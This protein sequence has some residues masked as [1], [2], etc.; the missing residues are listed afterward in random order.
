MGWCVR[1]C[2]VACW[3]RCAPGTRTA[4]A[5]SVE[6]RAR[7]TLYALLGEHPVDR[8]GRCR[9]C[10]G[11]RHRLW[12]RRRVCRVLVLAR[13]YLFQ[14]VDVLLADAA[15]DREPGSATPDRDA[16]EVLPRVLTDPNGPRTPP[17][18]PTSAVASPPAGSS[19]GARRPGT[20][21][22]GAGVSPCPDPRSRRAPP[23]DAPA[24]LTW[25]RPSP[26]GA[27]STPSQA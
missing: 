11:P 21:H 9:S 16:T 2:A 22:G 6:C 20:S 24:P 7:A 8:R 27:A 25:D 19:A 15:H 3:P 18:L 4:G 1:R 5:S 12:R 14:P 17:L 10:R 13:F 26:V 23:Q